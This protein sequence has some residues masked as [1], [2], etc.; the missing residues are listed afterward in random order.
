MVPF[1]A[2]LATIASAEPLRPYIVEGDAIPQPLTG[3]AGDARSGENLVADRQRGLCLLCHHAPLPEPHAQGT[4]APDLR[5]V[6]ARLSEGQIRLRIVDMAR[7]N[8]STI[9]PSYYRI[10]EYERVA[11]AWRGKPVLSADEIEDIVAYLVTLRE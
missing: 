11:S 2:S 9:M 6:G 3:Y 8:P 5:G 4:L 1:L 10:S 7:L